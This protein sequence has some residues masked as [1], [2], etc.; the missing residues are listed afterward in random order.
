MPRV[1]DTGD[2]PPGAVAAMAAAVRAVLGAV[3]RRWWMRA[4]VVGLTPPFVPAAPAHGAATFDSASV[5]GSALDR[6]LT[7]AACEAIRVSEVLFRSPRAECPQV[8]L[9]LGLDGLIWR[10]TPVHVAWAVLA[11]IVL[12]WAAR[13]DWSET[14]DSP[15]VRVGW[16]AA[17]TAGLAYALKMAASAVVGVS[18]ELRAAAEVLR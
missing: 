16:E 11:V 14:A 18:G 7:E 17:K 1:H 4:A 9:S 13:R 2:L 12:W 10:I 5:E 3:W 15:A 8:S 6:V